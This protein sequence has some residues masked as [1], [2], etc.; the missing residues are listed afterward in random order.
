MMIGRYKN[1]SDGKL[2][3][4]KID[5]PVKVDT[6]MVA[7]KFEK[8]AA[9]EPKFEMLT[10]GNAVFHQLFKMVTTVNKKSSRKILWSHIALLE[11]ELYK[12]YKMNLTFRNALRKH[13][14]SSDKLIIRLDL[15]VFFDGLDQEE[16]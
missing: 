2:S 14:G 16:D 9:Y 13:I 12:S 11:K 6:P 15:N 7:N 4:V 10:M 3:Q 1:Y 5:T 8:L